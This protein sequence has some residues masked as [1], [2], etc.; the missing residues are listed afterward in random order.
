MFGL[1]LEVVSEV[2]EMGL[3]HQLGYENGERGWWQSTIALPSGLH[4]IRGVHVDYRTTVF[5]GLWS[6]DAQAIGTLKARAMAQDNRRLR[7]GL[8]R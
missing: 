1:P 8:M 2:D 6:S 5:I 7:K 4:E 3:F